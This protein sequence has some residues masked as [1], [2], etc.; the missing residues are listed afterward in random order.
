[1]LHGYLTPAKG[2]SVHTLQ[3]RRFVLVL[4][5]K[6]YCRHSESLI[7][8]QKTLAGKPPWFGMCQDFIR[9]LVSQSTSS[10]SGKGPLNSY[11]YLR[12]MSQTYPSPFGIIVP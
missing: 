1:M 5:Y 11:R 2:F 3:G 9:S 8:F 10:G 7:S 4:E 12:L 6:G